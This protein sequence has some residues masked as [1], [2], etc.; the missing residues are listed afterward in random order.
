MKKTRRENGFGTLVSKGKGKPYLA[1]WTYQGKTYY[2]STGQINRK[3]ALKEL[4][5]LTRPFREENK[6]N[7]IQNLQYKLN[8]IEEN[9]KQTEL[10][11]VGILLEDLEDKYLSN[12]VCSD[13]TS[14][15]KRIYGTYIRSFLNFLKDSNY[16]IK[17]M[18]QVTKK[19]VE[20]YCQYLVDTCSSENYNNKIH[21]LRKIFN[22]LKE[23]GRY[24]EN[25][26]DDVKFR[27]QS[28]KCRRAFTTEELY[29]I[30]N[31]IKDDKQMLCL[32][33]LGLYTGLRIGDC[34]CL[35]WENVDLFKK[36]ISIVPNKTKRFNQSAIIIPIHDSLYNILCSFKNLNIDD[37]YV[38]PKIKD[39]Y[40]GGLLTAKIKKIFEKLGIN[41]QTTDENGKVKRVVSFH[42]L[43]HTFVSMNINNGLSPLLVQKI[44]GHSSID[45]TN[46]YF[47][48]NENVVRTGINAMPDLLENKEVNKIDDNIEKSE[49]LNLFDKDKDK[50]L[51][52][53]LNRII[54]F[55]K[56][57]VA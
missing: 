34:A 57:N 10:K 51:N 56:K 8:E 14:S 44:V 13:I 33:S 18:K 53:T 26:F 55:Y 32:F 25:P 41:M 42:S 20:E 45:M 5:K 48:S 9:I 1:K 21:T 24:I 6:I 35:K 29:K 52:D 23:E 3:D 39:Y 27:K 2:K 49:L 36:I 17:E 31:H 11:K 37:V 12:I 50:S 28:L 38:I 7:V 43:R 30:L 22:T 15:T 46:H 40:E 54:D 4:E 47:H 19:I 16:K